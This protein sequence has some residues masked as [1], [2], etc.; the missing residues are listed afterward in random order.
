MFSQFPRARQT[1]G[2][3]AV[4]GFAFVVVSPARAADDKLAVEPQEVA[5]IQVESADGWFGF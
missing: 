5:P 1:L 2:L 3:A 4:L